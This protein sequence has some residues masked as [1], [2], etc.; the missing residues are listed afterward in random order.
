MTGKRNKGT[1]IENN[2]HCP[3]PQ[4]M[5]LSER[6]FTEICRQG[7]IKEPLEFI[8]FT[9][10]AEYKINRNSILKKNSVEFVC[11]STALQ[12]CDMKNGITQKRNKLRA[13]RAVGR[14]KLKIPR[15]KF[16]KNFSF[17]HA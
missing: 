3:Y 8:V 12:K 13:W 10:F 14:K 16:R 15:K 5:C 11:N 4:I 1:M 9:K 7:Q 2:W 6:K 17:L